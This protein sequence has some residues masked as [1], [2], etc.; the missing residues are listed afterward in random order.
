[1]SDPA[2]EIAGQLF[3]FI[4]RAAEKAGELLADGPGLIPEFFRL[5]PHGFLQRVQNLALQAARAG[6]VDPGRVGTRPLR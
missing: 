5:R 3:A 1:M 4:A 2:L 6:L